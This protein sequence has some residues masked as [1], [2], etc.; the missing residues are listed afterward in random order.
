MDKQTQEKI[1]KAI[2]ESLP[3]QVG[4]VLKQELERIPK[5]EHQLKVSEDSIN[6]KLVTIRR[7]EDKVNELQHL[8]NKARSLELKEA[9][10]EKGE[11]DL[12]IRELEYQLNSEKDKS[13]F[14]RQVA[15]GLVRNTVF[16]ENVFD[17]VSGPSGT[18]QYG[19]IVYGNTTKNFTSEK[20]QE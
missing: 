6:D 2:K 4:E 18:D 11:R 8:E 19:N 3:S 5:L 13:E 10:L 12:K 16:K 1:E 20:T 15:L 17:N 7:L 9:A 14:A